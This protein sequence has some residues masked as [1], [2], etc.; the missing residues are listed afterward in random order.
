MCAEND[1]FDNGH[2]RANDARSPQCGKVKRVAL[3]LALRVNDRHI[4][5][6]CGLSSSAC[7]DPQTSR[8]LRLTVAHTNTQTHRHRSLHFTVI[9]FQRPHRVNKQKCFRFFANALAAAL[10]I[11][12]S[13]AMA[14]ARARPGHRRKRNANFHQ[15]RCVC[16]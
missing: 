16:N 15:P 2:Y 14:G 10:C 8:R 9:H 1:G 5:P 11:R 12:F 4:V 3:L 13:F 7:V 6:M